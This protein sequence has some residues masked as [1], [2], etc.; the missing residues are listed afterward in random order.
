MQYLL[1][2]KRSLKVCCAS[3]QALLCRLPS[4]QPDNSAHSQELVSS[5]S[6]DKLECAQ[7][8]AQPRRTRSTQPGGGGPHGMAF[9]AAGLR[10][11]EEARVSA[12][13]GLQVGSHRPAAAASLRGHADLH[14]SLQILPQLQAHLLMHCHTETTECVLNLLPTG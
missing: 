5:C 12:A 6:P 1:G 14:L 7:A 3:V 11:R 9:L 2:C 4:L 10:A 8:N 13:A